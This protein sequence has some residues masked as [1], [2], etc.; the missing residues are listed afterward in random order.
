MLIRS[1]RIF[2]DLVETRSFTLTARRNYLTQ[3]AISQHLAALERKFAVRLL[4]RSRRTI[5]VTA[6][7]R[8]LYDHAQRIVQQYTKLE[9]ALQKPPREVA[10]SVRV[11]AT[12]TVGLYELPPYL[13]AFL[14][15]YPR[16]DLQVTYLKTT[17]LIEA[18]LTG[19]ADLGVMANPEPNPQLH[20]ELLKKDRLVV[21]IPPRHV[22]AGHRH[23]RLAQLTGQ[24]FIAMAPGLLTR[25][26]LDRIFRACQVRVKIVYAF[27]NVELIKRAVE[28]EAGISILP[29]GTVRNEV[30][31]GTLRQLE[32]REGPFEHPIKIMTR[33]S[34][35]RSLPAQKFIGSLLQG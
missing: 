9:A 27:D 20:G 35:E 26:A 17:E 6:A 21:V 15:Q 22:W 12:L 28:V 30:A 33:R 25:K 8:V 24:A 19:R 5:G 32:I 16:I 23:I 10:G 7:G 18:V 4:D 13:T 11:V 29:A 34:E 31:A 14:K 1:L 2:A 3:S